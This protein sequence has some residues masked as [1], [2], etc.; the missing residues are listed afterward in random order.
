MRIKPK[1]SNKETE[2]YKIEK[3][4]IF[5]MTEGELDVYIDHHINDIES[6]KDYLKKLTKLAR[7]KK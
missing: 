6:I 7:Y 1:K 3:D 5:S 2:Q 4:S